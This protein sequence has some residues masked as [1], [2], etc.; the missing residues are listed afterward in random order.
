MAQGRSMSRRNDLRAAII[1][2]C[3]SRGKKYRFRW[4]E[5]ISFPNS[6]VLSVVNKHRAFFSRWWTCC[7]YLFIY[8]LDDSV[9]WELPNWSNCSRLIFF[10]SCSVY[11]CF[12]TL[13]PYVD[14]Y[15]PFLDYVWIYRKA[16][17]HKKPNPFIIWVS[18]FCVEDQMASI[19]YNTTSC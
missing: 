14:F 13:V 4:T 9:A 8:S 19:S 17:V 5:N 6:L 18:S 12:C 7:L 10:Y 1:H 15:S 11:G 16:T 3:V 2:R